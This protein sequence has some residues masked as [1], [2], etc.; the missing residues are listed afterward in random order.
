MGSSIGAALNRPR[1]I[2]FVPT[3]V[4]ESAILYGGEEATVIMTVGR[5]STND[6]L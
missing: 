6:L 4:H 1:K 3:D 5:R 2:F